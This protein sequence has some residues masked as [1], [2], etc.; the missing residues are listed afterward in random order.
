MFTKRKLKSCL[1]N[2]RFSLKLFWSNE[3]V[4]YTKFEHC[5]L[6]MFPEG[7]DCF[8]FDVEF[9]NVFEILKFKVKV[10]Q[11]SGCITPCMKYL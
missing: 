11:I 5:T 10:S 7:R 2:S 4:K 1:S 8:D 9:S 6:D 3:S